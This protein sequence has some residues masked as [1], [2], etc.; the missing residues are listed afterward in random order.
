[1]HVIFVAIDFHQGPHGNEYGY[2]GYDNGNYNDNYS[3]NNDFHDF[4]KPFKFHGFKCKFE[5]ILLFPGND[6]F[7]AT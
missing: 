3:D 6:A 5:K 4:F 7:I 2:G 1:M